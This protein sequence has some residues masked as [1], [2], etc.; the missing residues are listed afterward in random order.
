MYFSLD[1]GFANIF[2]RFDVTIVK[3]NPTAQG[4]F[5]ATGNLFTYVTLS[6]G[7][8]VFGSGFD[9]GIAVEAP[10]LA[11]TINAVA[12][13]TGGVCNN[14]ATKIGVEANIAAGIQ[15]FAYFGKDFLHPTK[16]VALFSRF[17]TIYNQCFPL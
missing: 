13:S 9:A 16:Q 1:L 14:P 4:N 7:A 11:G 6:A 10:Q 15:S 17:V 2:A 5:N 8:S 12:K 3:V